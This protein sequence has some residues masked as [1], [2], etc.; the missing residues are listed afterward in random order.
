MR[1]FNA[2]QLVCYFL[3]NPFLINW[4]FTN[5]FR[6]STVLGWISLIAEIVLFFIFITAITIWIKWCEGTVK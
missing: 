2:F 6:A 5:P 3:C 4:L 1:E